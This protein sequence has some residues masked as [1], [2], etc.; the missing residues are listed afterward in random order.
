MADS[1][2]VLSLGEHPR[3]V[4]PRDDDFSRSSSPADV[5]F[6]WGMVET[7]AWTPSQRKSLLLTWGA[8]L[9]ALF[10]NPFGARLVFYPLDLAFR[11]KLNIE[12][13]AEWVS[14]NFHDC[15]GKIVIVLLMV[16]A[17]QRHIA[18]PSLDVDRTRGVL[19]ALY[20]GL[21]YIRFLFLLGSW[22]RLCSR[23]H[24][25]SCP[26]TAAEL[27]T[28]VVNTFV[29]VLMI[30]GVVHYWPRESQLQAMVDEQYPA[31]RSLISQAHPPTGPIVNYYLWGGYINWKDPSLKV[32]VD[33]R[34][35]IFEYSGVFKDY[36]DL[37]SL[38]DPDALLDKYKV[39]YVL[40]PRGE[41]LTY[42]LQHDAKWK[43]R[44]TATE[45]RSAGENSER[46]RVAESA[47]S[48]CYGSPKI[49]YLAI[50][51]LV[52]VLRRMRSFRSE[53][54][55][56]SE[57]PIEFSMAPYRRKSALRKRI[58]AAYWECA[59]K[60]IQWRY[61][62]AHRLP[63][64]PPAEFSV[65]ASEAGRP[66][67]MTPF[68]AN[69]GR[70]CAD[71]D[72]SSGVENEY[73]W[74]TIPCRNRC[75]PAGQWWRATDA[76]NRRLLI[77]GVAE[78]P[79]NRVR[80]KISESR[81]FMFAHIGPE[82]LLVSLALLLAIV[83]PQLGASWFARAERALAAVARRR[84]LSVLLCGFSAL[85]M[86]LVLL[87]WLP[88]PHPVYQRRVQ[89]LAGRR[90][91]CPRTP[92]QSHA[93]H[94]GAFGNVPRHFSSDLCL[95]VSA[96][97]GIGPR[98]SA[99]SFLDTRSGAC[100]SASASC[101]R[102]SAGCCKPGFRPRGRCSAACCRCCALACSAIGTTAIGEARWRRPAEPWCW[103]PCRASCGDS[104]Y[105]MRF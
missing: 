3:I 9:V 57:M 17:G 62:Y 14:V 104:A 81:Q 105:A 55:L 102:P 68:A 29:I 30:A 20:S 53:F 39:R 23:R 13:V 74:N 50:I 87:P 2:S 73:E 98:L 46:S 35:D 72:V 5:P 56:Q 90:H 61:G 91:L 43:V 99:R 58:A 94:V 8:S 32:F 6:K 7:E 59:V 103:A 67:T 16:F 18:S 24:L 85:A 48:R 19:F 12:H 79:P 69:I 77:A 42:L 28:P 80:D 21:T 71:W 70:S 76:E 54:R 64:E 33:G 60:Q 38:K 10:V 83:R 45:Q 41:P 93:P 40:F 49:R 31:E 89:L 78:S 52:L 65:S 15:R 66:P 34:A 44:F 97:S 22:L 88:I 51:A 84:A 47:A 26:A 100:G 27:D 92:R 75:D 1:A 95:D 11:Q 96:A 86:R 82:A 63:D 101:A 36:L 37:L 25:I 4:V